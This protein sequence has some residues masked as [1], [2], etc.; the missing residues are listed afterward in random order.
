MQRMAGYTRDENV[1]DATAL[2]T[3]LRTLYQ[4]PKPTIARVHGD[5]YAGGAGLVAACDIAVSADT[6][7]YCLTEVRL[8]LVP[9]TISPYIV[10]AMGARNAHRYCLTGER[11]GA[12]EALRIGLVHE[13][14]PADKLD[15]KVAEVAQAACLGGPS[16]VKACKAILQ[17]VAGKDISQLLIERTVHTIA[18]VRVSE[19]GREGISAFLARRPPQ[20]LK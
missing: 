9:A 5:A 4:C 17:E 11:F 2:A 12:A 3:M 16:A 8:G 15:A 18:D 20:W 6:A 7:A 14:V 1:A 13:V 10:R 19:E